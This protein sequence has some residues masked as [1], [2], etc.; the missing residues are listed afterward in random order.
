MNGAIGSKGVVKDGGF[1]SV[2]LF[3]VGLILVIF[4]VG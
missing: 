4:V 2:V 3:E 1:G